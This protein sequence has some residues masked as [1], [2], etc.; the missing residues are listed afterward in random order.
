MVL[1][2]EMRL[3]AGLFACVFLPVPGC[4]VRWGGCAQGL[5]PGVGVY[6]GLASG[7]GAPKEASGPKWSQRQSVEHASQP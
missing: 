5:P 2:V 1:W 3:L 6:T 4:E 7:H